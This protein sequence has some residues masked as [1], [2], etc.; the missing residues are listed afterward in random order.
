[1]GFLFGLFIGIAVSIGLVVSFARYSNVRSIRRAE[2][3]R[4]IAAFARMTV[5]DSRKLLPGEFYPSWVLNW[6]NLELE[7]IWPY[8]NEA[9]SELIRSSVEPVLEQYTPAMIASLKFSKLTLGT[10]APQ[11][12]GVSILENESGPNGITMELEMQWDGNPK[13]VLDVKTLLGVALPIEVKNVGFTGVFRLIF[14]PLVDEFPCFGALSYSLR[15]KKG[16][17]FTLKVVG[18]ELTSIPGISDALEETILDAIEDSITWP[19][20]KIIP[21]LPGDYSDLELKPVGTLD[22]KLVQAKDLS[23]KDLIGKSDPYAVVF[24]RPLP[25]K[26][27][28]TKTIS[29]SL[30]PIWNEHFEFVV[31]DVSTQHLTVRV[32]DDEGVGSS[33]LIGAAQVPLNELEPGKVKDIWLKLVKDLVV[34]RDTKNRG[35]VQLELLYCPLGK[36]SGFKNPFNPN[37]SLTIL[38]KVLKPESEDSDATDVKSSQSPNK[39]DV[40]VRGVLSVTVVAAE[41]LPAV[42]FMGK[43]DPFVVITLK[44][45]E[46]KSKT[47]V[48]PDS[49]NPVWNQT[50][51]FVVEDALHDLLIFEVWDHDKFGKDK[52]GR[53][54]MTLTRVMLEGEFQEWYALD[55]AKSGKLCI[56]LK[57]TPRLKL[58][59][60]S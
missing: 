12:T 53:V 49:L 3:A 57:W 42:D 23:N 44:K 54:I 2:L 19:V 17:D 8:V 41:D 11:F 39:T 20:R 24:I 9:A 21:I 51:D 14:K 22:V 36:E 37:Y 32:F 38:E 27:K 58:R 31:E 6:L 55:G 47:R 10:V 56:H 7:K 29:N 35:Q 60:A 25:N 28:K 16:L 40:I 15:E 1:M 5:Q 48:V 34:Q 18:G 26:T 4:T 33:Q 13:I 52:I 46:A 45:S 59:D 50:F 30:N 43:A